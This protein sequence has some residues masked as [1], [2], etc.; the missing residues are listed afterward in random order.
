MQPL[1]LHENF[2]RPVKHRAKKSDK[3]RETQIKGGL[4]LAA[5]ELILKTPTLAL[6]KKFRKCEDA[7]IEQPDINRCM[8]YADKIEEA[9]KSGNYI[10]A[11]WNA[12][13][14]D[15]GVNDEAFGH[16]YC[17][18]DSANKLKLKIGVTTMKLRTRLQK[19]ETRHGH[20]SL[21]ELF[22][23]YVRHP[24]EIE[25]YIQEKL[26]ACH[27]GS[28]SRG[29]SKEWYYATPIEASKAF[30]LT[31]K[32]RR[33]KVLSFTVYMK[34]CPD[35]PIIETELR[36]TLPVQEYR[37]DRVNWATWD[38]STEFDRDSWNGL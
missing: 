38:M 20:E 6:V 35:Y 15:N 16:V 23:I 21:L 14:Y 32:E 29:N 27:V 12:R 28:A 33:G 18:M 37:S 36:A 24:Y 25:K 34:N 22:S 3:L 9:I 8:R 2:L 11:P 31:I 17:V 13:S 26:P 4:M 30:S 1:N 7:W 5:A 19:M 10:N